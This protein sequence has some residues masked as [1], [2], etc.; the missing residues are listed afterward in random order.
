MKKQ[1]DCLDLLRAIIKQRPN[2]TRDNHFH[3]WIDSL[4]ENKH[5]EFRLDAYKRLL[6]LSYNDCKRQ[7][8]PP[9]VD[10][11]RQAENTASEAAAV[12]NSVRRLNHIMLCGK[13]L[14]DCTGAEVRREGKQWEAIADAV[15]PSQIV[16]SVLTEKEIVR[17]LSQSKPGHRGTRH[18][19]V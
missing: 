13:L 17:L 16:G 7:L 18:A 12:R 2:D 15:K 8:F 6:Q 10:E 9:S 3:S 19:Q 5:V 14:K 1:F 4:E 11:K